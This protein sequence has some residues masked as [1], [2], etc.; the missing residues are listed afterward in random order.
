MLNN[1]QNNEQF[2]KKIGFLTSA[3]ISNQ[4]T[5]QRLEEL[6]TKHR[7]LFELPQ[8]VLKLLGFG[9]KNG[10]LGLLPIDLDNHLNF[11]KLKTEPYLFHY[12]FVSSKAV[13]DQENHLAPL[14]QF[15]NTRNIRQ[16]G[17]WGSPNKSFSSFLKPSFSKVVPNPRKGKGMKLLIDRSK[18]LSKRQV[19]CDPEM[20]MPSGTRDFE[21]V[22]FD[23]PGHAFM[24]FGGI[25]NETIVRQ[26]VIKIDA[27]Y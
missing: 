22:Q 10:K 16:H 14:E 3:D 17:V 25:P 12:G 23:M 24:V 2:Q 8:H 9:I 4:L 15:D 27:I 26:E 7:W 6:N 13:W 11:L 5:A 20:F 21:G 19:Y 1:H 18:L